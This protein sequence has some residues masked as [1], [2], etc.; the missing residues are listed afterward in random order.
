M[1][2]PPS[3]L[4]TRYSICLPHRE[5]TDQKRGRGGSYCRCVSRQGVGDGGI[6]T[7]ATTN[8]DIFV[9]LVIWT[10]IF[11][12]IYLLCNA[13]KIPY[14][15]GGQYMYRYAR[16]IKAGCVYAYIVYVMI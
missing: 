16:E 3:S 9:I 6:H 4:I 14:T 10:Q 11:R 8:L 2:S 7:S 1:C 12:K 13:L 5:N 15:E